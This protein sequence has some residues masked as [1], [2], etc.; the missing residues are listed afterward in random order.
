[1]AIILVVY[2]AVVETG[3]LIST[4]ALGSKHDN[5]IAGWR[6]MAIMDLRD[7]GKMHK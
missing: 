1:M 6:S 4:L 3:C 2:E 5:D 7:A